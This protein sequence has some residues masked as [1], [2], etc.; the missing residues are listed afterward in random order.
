MPRLTPQEAREK[1]AQRTSAATQDYVAGVQRVSTAPGQAAAAKRDKWRAGIQ[2]SEAK[3]ARNVSRVSL[4]EWQESASNVGAQRFAA[5]AQAK[6]GKYERFA[7]EFYP[8]LDRGI[9]AVKG[10]DDTTQ[11][12]RIQRAV[13]MMRHNAQFRR[14]GG[15]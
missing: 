9:Q 3:W 2:N 11:E 5:G 6:S 8:H 10:M 15:A 14:G 13:A 7:A 12:A 1:W 4:A